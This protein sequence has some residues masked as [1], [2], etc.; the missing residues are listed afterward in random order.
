MEYTDLAACAQG[1]MVQLPKGI[2]EQLIDVQ[3][4]VCKDPD[5]ASVL[6][7]ETEDDPKPV[8]EDAKGMFFGHPAEI[9]EGV[10]DDEEDPAEEVIMPAGVIILVASNI[11]DGD[12][13]DKVLLHEIGHALGLTEDEIWQWDLDAGD[14]DDKEAKSKG[15]SSDDAKDSKERE[16]VSGSPDPD[17]EN[18]PTGVGTADA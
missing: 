3:I 11:E 7:A 16:A 15:E 18:A 6:L 17:K 5:M 2:T 9:P 8:A 4:A 13:A 10:P 12:I 14:K 1:L